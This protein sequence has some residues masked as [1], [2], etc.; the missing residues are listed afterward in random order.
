MVLLALGY[1]LA[2]KPVY[3]A[4]TRMFVSTSQGASVS[5]A[6]QGNLYS[7]QRVVSYTK[8]LTGDTLARRTIE[9]M[10]LDLEPAELAAMVTASAA[11]NTVLIDVKV[12]DTVPARAMDIANVLSAQFVEFVKELETP[13]KGA[14]PAARVVI[15]E[16][17][18][19]P[20]APVLPT[21][22]RNIALAGVLGLLLGAGAA[23]LRDRLDNTV[24]DRET[25]EEVTE[26][27]V[28]GT[29]PFDKRRESDPSINF[30]EEAGPSAESF[31]TLRTNLQFLNVDNPPRAIVI[32]SSLPTEGKSTTAINLAL[33]LAEAGHKVL[34]LEGDLR[35]PIATKYLNVVGSVG[36][37]NVLA[38]QASIEDVIQGTGAQLRVLAAGP[39][40]PNPSEL[41]GSETAKATI[42]KLRAEFDYV[43]ID[44]PPVLPVTDATILAAAADGVLVI[45]RYGKTKRDQLARAVDNLRGVNANVL[46]AIMTM[47]PT[48]KSDT[49]YG[50]AYQYSH[51]QKPN[52]SK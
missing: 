3:E 42:A 52:R 28:V 49:Y 18:Y 38:R 2:T 26:I 12:R 5:D 45:A 48:R 33:A 10:K 17:A 32:T 15:E 30:T 50:Y 41:L 31:R 46:G 39:V 44:A 7:Q 34:L 27:G 16:R 22:K 9:E 25:V 21:T 47:T 36:F 14:D 8:L 11:P 4:S 1:S 35:R 43:I 37:S 6:Y 19:E 20:T 40:P 13:K 23:L 51:G 29:I 24:K